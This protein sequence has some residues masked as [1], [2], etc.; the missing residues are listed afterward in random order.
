MS[1]HKSRKVFTGLTSYVYER[2]TIRLKELKYK[3]L[4][5]ERGGVRYGTSLRVRSKEKREVG[6]QRGTVS[7]TDRRGRENSKRQRNTVHTGV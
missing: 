7:R 3:S 6:Y 2:I 5:T 1:Q 4:V